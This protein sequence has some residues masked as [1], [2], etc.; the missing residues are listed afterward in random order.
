[1][2]A[3]GV[4]NLAAGFSIARWSGTRNTRNIPHGLSQTPEFVIIRAKNNNQSWQ[5]WHKDYTS[6]PS[7][8]YLD[9]A[10]RDTATSGEF[11]QVTAA[12]VQVGNSEGSNS[13]GTDN[14][15]MYA[16]HSVPGYSAFGSW[17][18][19]GVRDGGFIPTGFRPALIM[20]KVTNEASNW[21][22]R[23]AAQSPYN[24]CTTWLYANG[25]A[26]E[27]TSLSID[28]LSNG[29]KWREDGGQG[30]N[31]GQQCVFAAFAEHPFGGANVSPSPAR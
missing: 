14:M 4:R 16:W 29:F 2:T 11:T 26:G 7:V 24:P 19:N 20:Y 8:M 25:T 31:P 6:Q 9:Q 18:A 27:N 10:Q 22:I 1:M 17:A 13:V 30:N 15:M 5:V 21:G 3:S 28:I 12:H 23:T